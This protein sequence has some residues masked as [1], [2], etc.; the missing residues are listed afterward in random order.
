MLCPNC[1]QSLP[2][3]SGFC[4]YCGTKIESGPPPVRA[5]KSS[6]S[7][8]VRWIIN[9]ALLAAVIALAV[10]NISQ[11]H[12]SQQQ[13]ALFLSFQEKNTELL[14]S[15]S[16]TSSRSEY[17]EEVIYRHQSDLT[18]LLPVISF[19]EGRIVILNYNLYGVRYYVLHMSA[20]CPEFKSTGPYTYTIYDYDDYDEILSM[21]F[22]FHI[23][24]NY[25]CH[26][27]R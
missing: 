7:A 8:L 16:D 25:K 19:F 21:D 27:V 12:Q 6:R 13:Q 4:M 22:W 9:A 1:N 3:D 10:L 11:Y 23:C 20:Q 17:Y 18:A 2:D 14:Q 26:V 5:E 24:D 15:I